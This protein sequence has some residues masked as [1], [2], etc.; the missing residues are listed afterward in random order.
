MC[1]W[2]KWMNEWMEVHKRDMFLS[3]FCD[4]FFFHTWKKTSWKQIWTSNEHLKKISTERIKEPKN[5]WT[6]LWISYVIYATY[7]K[8]QNKVG[9]IDT[10]AFVQ[11]LMNR[12]KEQ[13]KLIH[14][15]NG[16]KIRQRWMVESP[17][18]SKRNEYFL[19]MT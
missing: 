8:W 13:T 17:S 16:R 19:L 1:F 5:I 12:N 10:E 3:F 6:S 7:D 11:K 15:N 14:S 18:K 9:D 4:T 2:F